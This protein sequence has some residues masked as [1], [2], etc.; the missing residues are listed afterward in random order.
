MGSKGPSGARSNWPN[1]EYDRSALKERSFA[2]LDGPGVIDASVAI[3]SV[4]RIRLQSSHRNN[5]AV[6]ALLWRGPGP[7]RS[8]HITE[9]SGTGS[10]RALN[11]DPRGAPRSRGDRAFGSTSQ[12]IEVF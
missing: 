7:G 2:R 1:Q 9:S 3:L 6:R 8:P 10:S 4:F 5:C 12:R 11:Y